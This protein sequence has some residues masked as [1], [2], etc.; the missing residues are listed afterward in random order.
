MIM[1]VV[2]MKLVTS[3]VIVVDPPPVH[4]TVNGQSIII[5]ALRSR[6]R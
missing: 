1:I 6:Q 2:M 4:P 5:D 3:S